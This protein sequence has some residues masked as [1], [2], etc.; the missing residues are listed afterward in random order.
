ME[1]SGRVVPEPGVER[2]VAPASA[3]EGQAAQ[4]ALAAEPDPL[5]HPLL[6]QILHIRDGLEPVGQGGGEQVL[7]QQPLRRRPN[8]SP[9]V[10]GEQ[11]GAETIVLASR[12]V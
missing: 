3:D 2:A 9:A 7:D 4:H 5:Q 1:R 11:Q 10:L 12:W 6:G 8:P